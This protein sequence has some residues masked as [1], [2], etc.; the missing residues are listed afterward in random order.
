VPQVIHSSQFKER[1]QFTDK[2]TVM[3]VGLG[4]TG[5]DLSY[6]AVTHPEVERV[7][8]C[9]RDGFHFAP[10]VCEVDF[11][12]SFDPDPILY[13]VTPAQS[14]SQSLVES[15]I[16]RSLV[17]PLMSAG[18]ISSIQH[19]SIIPCD[20]T[21]NYFGSTTTYTSSRCFG[22]ARVQRQEWISG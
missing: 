9:H 6:L 20:R 11:F 3:I 7:V 17:F 14:C 22:L 12:L 18:R 15:L 4:E 8:V 13:S 21:T 10:K 2:K 19:T 1:R 16:Q 5:A